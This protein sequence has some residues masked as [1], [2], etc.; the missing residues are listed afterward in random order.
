MTGTVSLVSLSTITAMP[1]PQ[2]GWQPQLNWPQSACGPWQIR[3][4]QSQN[5]DMNEIGNQSRAGSPRPV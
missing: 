4:L 2:F 1:A 5:V 3:S